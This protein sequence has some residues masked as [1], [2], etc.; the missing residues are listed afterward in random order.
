MIRYCRNY[1]YSKPVSFTFYIVTIISSTILAY[2]ALMV[3]SHFIDVLVDG[4][5]KAIILRYCGLIALI[6]IGNTLIKTINNYIITVIQTQIVYEGSR[7]I[8]K[9]LMKLPVDYIKQQDMA[10]MSQRINM[11]TN[12]CATFFLETYIR[13][14]LSV[15]S[16]LV[17]I[18]FITINAGVKLAIIISALM[19]IYI[20]VYVLFR[21]VIYRRANRYR[22]KTAMF[23]GGYFEAL[24]NICFAKNHS[25]ESYYINKLDR[26][27]KDLFRGVLSYRR[28]LL[29]TNI[30][31]EGISIVSTVIIYIICGMAIMHGEMTIGVVIAV[32]NLFGGVID[33][34]KFLLQYGKEYQDAKV[35]YDRIAELMK[36]QELKDGELR[37]DSIDEIL[38]DKVSFGYQNSFINNFTMRLEKGNVY[39]L[40]GK[41]GS[42]KSTFIN[43]ILGN[44]IN[45][46]DGN[47]YYNDKN[48][49]KI[50]MEHVKKK[51]IGYVEQDTVLVAGT[52]RE[53]LTLF[54]EDN[55]KMDKY[56]QMLNLYS[57]KDNIGLTE[58]TYVNVQHN[59]ISGGEKQ[60][61][62][63]IRQLL[64]N[65]EV[66]IFDEPTAN[67]EPEMK[68][69][70]TRIIHSMRKDKIII[71]A[72]HD[73]EIIGND[74]I[75]IE[76]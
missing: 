71:I 61:I 64:Q 42:G 55:K 74:D 16:L 9:K 25:K 3:S 58:D 26:V 66:L 5:N 67:L 50:N 10:Y 53:N 1:A 7:D 4:T 40:I 36:R 56:T 12:T 17:S 8:Y 22:E 21:N 38:L 45:E 27:F 49:K 19:I 18:M 37:L 72:T 30:C 39:F 35:S 62:S 69:M 2:I 43:I 41:N 11:D 15:I 48:I 54:A 68:T 34:T 28:I 60:K 52:V 63:I 47:I 76:I 14:Y 13:L 70:F 33:S 29:S 20:P 73:T 23:F 24:S 75:I 44:H 46:M 51:N 32:L 31:E 59:N 57:A 65:P 6:E